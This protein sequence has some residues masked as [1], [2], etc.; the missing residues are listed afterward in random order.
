[1]EKLWKSKSLYA[2]ENQVL[3]EAANHILISLKK[4]LLYGKM[5]KI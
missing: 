4:V 1:M 5:S 2:A 3:R